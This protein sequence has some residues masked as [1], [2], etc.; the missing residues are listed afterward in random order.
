MPPKD[1]KRGRSRSG[2]PKSAGKAKAKAT[3]AAVETSSETRLRRVRAQAKRTQQCPRQGHQQDPLHRGQSIDRCQG[4]ARLQAQGAQYDPP[5]TPATTSSA[6]AAVPVADAALP[7]AAMAMAALPSLDNEM[8]AS[9]AVPTVPSL[10]TAITG[11]R[12]PPAMLAWHRLGHHCLRGPPLLQRLPQ[13]RAP[14]HLFLEWLPRLQLWLQAGRSR[15]TSGPSERLCYKFWRSRYKVHEPAQARIEQCTGKRGGA[16]HR[17]CQ[18]LLQIPLDPVSQ[19]D[20]MV[21]PLE[22]MRR[23]SSFQPQQQPASAPCLTL[24]RSDDEAPPGQDAIT[25]SVSF[26][27]CSGTLPSLQVRNSEACCHVYLGVKISYYSSAKHTVAHRIQAANHAWQR[28]R[29]ILCSRT[30][31]DVGKRLA[32]WK[33]TVIPTLM[34]GLAASAPGLKDISRMQHQLTRQAR[35]IT[36]IFAHLSKVS[37][38]ELHRRFRLSTVL[39]MLHKEA[40]ALHHQLLTDEHLSSMFTQEHLASARD[41]AAT[42]Q[43]WQLQ[44]WSSSQSTTSSP[45]VEAPF[46]CHHC[47]KAYCTYRLLRSMNPLNTLRRRPRRTRYCLTELSTA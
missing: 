41:T 46:Q 27:D 33:A 4:A 17:S 32:I 34:Y 29:R 40:Q 20:C 25:D 18:L 45:S 23:G 22:E 37:T 36:H 39:D 43:A 1:S 12:P 42:M 13:P 26:S 44:Q 9:D 11:P 5:P 14:G 31:L 19:V 3:A 15:S 10:P 47:G 24:P 2:R 8:P 28:L 30:Q 16:Q 7:T 6:P 38:Q 21:L 35:A